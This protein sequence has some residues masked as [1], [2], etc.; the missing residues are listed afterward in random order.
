MPKKTIIKS[1][2]TEYGLQWGINRAIYST[3]LKLLKL[4]PATEKLYEKDPPFPTQLGLFRIDVNALRQFIRNELNDAEK[5]QLISIADDACVGTITGF[6][7]IKLDYGN[8]ID[9][10]LNPLTGK[11]CNKRTEWYK[12]PDFDDERGDIKVI[13]EASR[14]SHFITLSRAYLLTEDK[15]YFEAF[16]LQL[17]D[18]LKNNEYG[19]GANFKCSQECSLRLVNTLLAFTVFN[20]CGLIQS[21]DVGNVNKLINRSY[22]KILSNFF[23]AYK[24]IKNNHTIS[25][26]MGM[27]AGA[28]CCGD[29]KQLNKAY[30]WLD[31]VI[32]EQFTDDGGYRQ[33]SFNYQRLA[34]QDIESI[35]AMSGATGKTISEANICKIRK[36]ALLMYQ[37]QDETGDMPNYGS[38]DG[39]LVFPVTSCGYRDF[40]PIINSIYALTSGRRL[41]DRGT[42]QEEL[43]WFSSGKEINDFK[44]EKV[45]RE[46]SQFPDAGLFTIRNGNA[47][48]MVVANDYRS[49]PAHMDQLHFDLW[50]DGINV[51]CDAGTYSYASD[52]GRELVKNSSHN[53]VEVNG[54][55]QMNAHGPFMILDWTRRKAVK[56][57]ENAFEGVIVSQNGYVHRRRVRSKEDGFEIVDRVSADAVIHFHTPY[58]TTVKDN[59][60]II[61]KDG[62]ELCRIIGESSAERRNS[63]RSLYYLRNEQSSDIFFKIR[64]NKDTIIKIKTGDRKN[65]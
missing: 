64:A 41:Y 36:A 35:M 5:R 24:C 55:T 48:A 14:F 26:L 65:D 34:L 44:N 46:S 22:R 29:S 56:G 38:N 28:W 61:F 57:T 6:S 60:A 37:C 1:I 45:K 4:L 42:L 54:K 15:K 17:A 32:D 2:I 11:T 58:A 40:R 7:S 47:W 8:P 23:Y 21:I 53:T 12:I 25:E 3:K 63:H 16:R 18:W 49:R 39:A 27:I 10:Q 52:E 30:K 20:D 33:F 31:E 43:I 19:H 62:N 51:F 59:E 9:W 13:W 50:V